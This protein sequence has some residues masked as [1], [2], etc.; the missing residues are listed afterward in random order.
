MA[1]LH[2]DRPGLGHLGLV[3]LGTVFVARVAACLLRL[4]RFVLSPAFCA[5]ALA[6]AFACAFSGSD[7]RDIALFTFNDSRGAPP[8]PSSILFVVWIGVELEVEFRLCDN[9]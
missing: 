2:V 1:G 6:F 3:G 9:L 5:A 4:L 7:T 8:L